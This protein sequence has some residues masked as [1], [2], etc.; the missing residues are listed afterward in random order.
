MK[1]CFLAP[2]EIQ[3]PP[4]GWGALETVVWNLSRSLKDL[5][6]EVFIINEKDSKLALSQIL[7]INPDIVHLHYGKHWEIMPKIKC[8]KFITTHDGSFL[9]SMRFHENL[10]RNFF[11]DCEFRVLTTWEKD[12]L[13][14]IGISP[15][16]INIF[17][18][19]VCYDS[20]SR[21][22]TPIH[23][24][25]ICLGK[26]DPRKK[27]SELQ[28]SLKNICFVGAVFDDR[29]NSKCS[30]YLGVW[31]RDDVYSKL[32]DFS[33]LTLLS[34]LELHPLVCLE[35]LSAGLG[36]V[37]SK[38]ASQNLDTSKNF[39]DVIPEEKL[40]DYQYIQSVL[41]KNKNY[42]KNNRGEIF[43]YAKSFKWIERAKKYK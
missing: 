25:T 39:I 43:E 27:Q 12:F 36:L 1:I 28:S 38:N 22:K 29:F 21:K 3:I 18:N 23:D 34:D 7:E 40:H 10:V 11:Y 31:N 35:A 8:R 16:N 30:S 6:H 32:T 20:F 33:N 24:K 19:G 14:N 17:A 15:K 2:G 41:D 26:I 9:E 4:I 37:I 13:L 5:G 42:C